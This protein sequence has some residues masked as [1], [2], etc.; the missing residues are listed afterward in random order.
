MPYPRPL[1]KM[2]VTDAM[3]VTF[4]Y[5]KWQDDPDVLRGAAQHILETALEIRVDRGSET[6]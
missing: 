5:Q 3:D 4:P 6:V 1:E 2:T